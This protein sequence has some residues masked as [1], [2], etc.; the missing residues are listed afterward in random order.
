MIKDIIYNGITATPSDYSSPDGDLATAINLIPEEGAL[1]P[2]LPPA[3]LK[4]QNG[5]ILQLEEGEVLKH[6][7]STTSYKHYITQKE[8]TIYYIDDNTGEKISILSYDNQVFDVKS[9]G[10]VLF[11]LTDTGIIFLLW[12][13]DKEEEMFLYEKIEID[14]YKLFQ[15]GL[16]LDDVRTIPEEP[17]EEPYTIYHDFNQYFNTVGY[18]DNTTPAAAWNNYGNDEYREKVSTTMMSELSNLI[19]NSEKDNKFVFPFLVRYA[20]KMYDGSIANPSPAV[21]MIPSS[22]Y[23]PY[24]GMEIIGDRRIDRYNEN[25]TNIELVQRVHPVFIAPN[26]DLYYKCSADFESLK[27][28][29]SAINIYVSPP[30]YT[31]N[32]N[33]NINGFHTS[34]LNG[35]YQESITSYPEQTLLQKSI[36]NSDMS[37]CSIDKGVNFDK[38][39]TINL[40]EDKLNHYPRYFD[41]KMPLKSSE[42]IQE[43]IRDCSNFYLI[44]SI[45][46]KD[47]DNS[48]QFV[49][50]EMDE[51][52]LKNLEVQEQLVSSPSILLDN[53]IAKDAFVYNSRLNI[54]N[55]QLYN[56]FRY[57]TNSIF[58]CIQN[59]NDET[60]YSIQ[61]RFL[62][63]NQEGNINKSLI[64]GNDSV[65]YMNT[66]LL[67]YIYIPIADIEKAYVCITDIANGTKRVFEVSMS[68]HPLMAGSYHSGDLMP[69]FGF[70]EIY[71]IFGVEENTSVKEIDEFPELSSNTETDYNVGTEIRSSLVNN[72]FLFSEENISYLP[73]DIIHVNTVARPLSEGQFGQYPLYAFTKNGIYAIEV[74]QDGS[75]S[76]RQPISRDVCINADG[77]L[78]IDSAVL[79]PTDR[80]IMLISGR[81]TTCITDSITSSDVFELSQLPNSDKLKDIFNGFLGEQLSGFDK[82]DFREFVKTCRGIYDYNGQRIIYYTKD[83]PYAYAFSLKSKSWGMILSDIVSSIDAYP[84]AIAQTKD[85]KLID[86]SSKSEI[87]NVPVLLITRPFSMGNNQYKTIQT[88]I[89][90][91]NLKRG[92][93]KQV[94]YGSNDLEHWHTIW[95]STDEN[96]RGF[97]GSPYKYFRLAVIGNL[98]KDESIFGFTTEFENRLTNRL[99]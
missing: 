28:V 29:V 88:I 86:F 26:F 24:C 97:R 44:K 6:I 27:D 66:P 19:S 20:F 15:F 5:N 94:L 9:I 62:T 65:C 18:G 4:L 48:E 77:I 76:S 85:N 69:V 57:N 67:R 47:I 93:V 41:A 36:L 1:V 38:H 63:Y 96:M 32:P 60:K 2:Q 51:E 16:V 11:A 43:D 81:E 95:S 49:K 79:F 84:K 82:L 70:D 14:F 17:V 8:N 30:I 78:Q 56:D 31:Y 25:L 34:F 98:D 21:L 52:T 45:P 54:Y 39:T 83:K 3:E 42:K 68:P 74:N 46:I 59:K 61:I 37:V 50:I 75:Y 7:H 90:R 33:G 71:E 64:I 55:L 13:L 35:E 58:T 40:I 12:K 22:I 23:A 91:G 80:G 73:S 53:I 89:Q 72:P 92:H 87:K 99:R 10:N